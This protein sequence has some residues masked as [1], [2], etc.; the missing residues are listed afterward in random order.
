MASTHL[1]NTRTATFGDLIGNGKR[2]RVPAYQRNYS[3]GEE[4]W[5]DLWNDIEALER[6]V[7]ERHYMGA[8]VV[9]V[10]GE[11]EFL[12][13]DGQQRLTTLSVLALAVI[14]RLRSLGADQAERDANAERAALLRRQFIGDK[15]P[16]SLTEASKLTLGEGNGGF[17][18]D[19]LVQLRAPI[20][21]R[22]LSKSNRLLW[23]CLQWY[24]SRLAARQDS[25]Q[26]LAR[27]LD[28]VV[29]LQLMFILITVDDELDAY[30]VFETLNARGLELSTSD[31]LKNWLFSRV[32]VASDREVLQRRWEQVLAT[33]R[34]ERFA[35]FLRYHLLC[36]HARIRKERLF[37]IVRD[38][39]RDGA[40][41]F[42]L[43][44]ALE[45]RAELFAALDDPTHGWW[46]DLPAAR[47]HVRELQVFRTRQVMPVLF[48]AWE[49]LLPDDFVRVLK[50]LAV[51][52][53]RHT[54]V[55]G[56]NTN[57]LE[58]V[59]HAAARALLSGAA[60]TP[61]QVFA[62]LRPVYVDDPR[63]RS[64]FAEWSV[65]TRGQR[66]ALV[67]YVLCRLESDASGRH[68]DFDT[69]ASSIE[70]VLPENPDAAWD[71]LVPPQR[72]ADLVH[73]IGNLSLL[74]PGI[75]RNIGNAL[76]ADKRSRYAASRYTLTTRLA[77]TA[78]D[79]WTAAAI[80]RRQS[81]LAER[82]VHLW[83]SDF[84]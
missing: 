7:D 52:S 26:Q 40:A 45:P 15:S 5:E 47:P 50:L 41:V 24:R 72:Q 80:D 44:D 83:R 13:I 23:Q 53:F 75:N 71:S 22:G 3:W 34:E 19:Y 64:D 16:A 73:R 42:A 61:S 28:Q 43:M 33:V 76:L 4:Q 21:P 65:D 30:T 29:G 6:G 9:E 66:K 2:Y 20:N 69:D 37:K 51:L 8:L 12:I 17:Y 74:E 67:R 54:V 79:E 63:F 25:G 62:A 38:S 27:L 10:Q 35:D 48:A 46:V 57:E 55:G 59:Y 70:H 14:E 60:S 31:L 82:A 11:R 58:P 81:E 36:E 77:Q 68:V 78:P 32:K 84:A 56:R 39:V 49:R 1:L 18:N